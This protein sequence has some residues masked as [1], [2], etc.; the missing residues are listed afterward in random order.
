MKIHC[1][2]TVFRLHGGEVSVGGVSAWNA[3]WYLFVRRGE[4]AD[5]MMI[6]PCLPCF[7]RHCIYSLWRT[8]TT[9]NGSVSIG[10]AVPT[11]CCRTVYN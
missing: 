2:R 11:G 5:A 3:K 6:A 4:Q 1:T 8:P 7:A 9:E 10:K